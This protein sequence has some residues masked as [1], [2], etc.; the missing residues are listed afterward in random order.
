MPVPS[1]AIAQ[2]KLAIN[3]LA[4]EVAELPAGA[5]SGV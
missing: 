1:K 3:P 4:E 2:Q 5:L